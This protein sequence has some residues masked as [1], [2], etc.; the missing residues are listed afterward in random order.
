MAV[1]DS[2]RRWILCS[3]RPSDNA[4]ED[5]KRTQKIW[6][7]RFLTCAFLSAAL[8]LCIYPR[9]SPSSAVESTEV[10]F[11]TEMTALNPMPNVSNLTVA[12]LWRNKFL[13]F[14]FSRFYIS[15]QCNFAYL[16]TLKTAS[17]VCV[18]FPLCS[19]VIRN[20][21]ISHFPEYQSID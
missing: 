21:H 19:V 6:T 8:M 3:Q 12:E 10:G 1:T 16:T 9:W 18:Y 11:T 14:S 4:K 13:R 5:D 15:E 20:I 2:P 17:S 7:V